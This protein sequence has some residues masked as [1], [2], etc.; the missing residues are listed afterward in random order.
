VLSNETMFVVE[1]IKLRYSQTQ[2]NRSNVAAAELGIVIAILS[3]GSI[4]I[5][6]ACVQCVV[7]YAIYVWATKSRKDD[8]TCRSL[9]A[10][11]LV[12][13]GEEEEGRD[14]ANDSAS[15]TEGAYR[16]GSESEDEQR[17]DGSAPTRNVRAQRH[18]LSID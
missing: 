16:S 13:T 11:E 1:D 7:R 8:K 12:V 2:I 10:S 4:L 6:F 18:G 3:T 5:L 17:H 14:V 9:S 15:N